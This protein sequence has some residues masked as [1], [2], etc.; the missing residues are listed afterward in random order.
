MP[1]PGILIAGRSIAGDAPL[2]NAISQIA[3]TVTR[4][5][6]LDVE[7]TLLRYP[8][9]RL[10]LLE[11]DLPDFDTALLQRWRR[12]FPDVQIVI[13]DGSVDRKLLAKAFSLGVKD[14]FSKPLNRELLVER[15]EVLMREA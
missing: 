2:V 15:V 6:P 13:I 10:L 4:R 12:A 11:I 14:A 5:S 1:H 9:V 3:A 7:Q 8:T